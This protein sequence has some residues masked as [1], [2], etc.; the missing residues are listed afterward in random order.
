MKYEIYEIKMKFSGIPKMF[1]T[2]LRISLFSF[3]KR[4]L[5]E[6]VNEAQKFVNRLVKKA[7]FAHT[8]HYY[9]FSDSL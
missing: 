1:V 7:G 5:Y 6:P 3:V 2:N 8:L 4:P 9:C